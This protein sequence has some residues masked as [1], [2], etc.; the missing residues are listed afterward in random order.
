MLSYPLR[1]EFYPGKEIKQ[2]TSTELNIILVEEIVICI[3]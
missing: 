2:K 1:L 3:T